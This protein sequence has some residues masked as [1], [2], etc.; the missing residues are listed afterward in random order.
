MDAIKRK[1]L[2]VATVKAAAAGRW[3]D[4][5]QRAGVA[6]DLLDG[7]H[8][9]CPK[10]GGT[11]RFRVVD[12]G[13]GACLC[14]KCFRD[15]NGD[16]LAAVMWLLGLDFKDALEWT[17]EQVG[18]TSP[19][20]GG[21]VAVDPLELLARVKRC[22]VEGLRRYGA[23]TV[24]DAVSFPVFLRDAVPVSSFKIWPCESGRRG[25]G[26]LAKGKPSGVFLPK[27]DT[28]SPRLPSPGESWLVVEGVK[29]AAAASDLGRLAIGLNGCVIP[30]EAAPLLS[31]VDVVLVPD[32]DAAGDHGAEQSA[33][34]LSGLA[35]SVRIA[36]LPVPW[37]ES[38]G[39][40]LRDAVRLAGV[41]SV[42][43]SLDAAEA[44]SP[45]PVK[46]AD[47]V[48]I[49]ESQ[50]DQQ[51]DRL[52]EVLAARG[53]L[54]QRADS[55]VIVKGDGMVPLCVDSL[56]FLASKHT[57]LVLGGNPVPWS[58]PVLRM[59][60]R[61]P[62][63]WPWVPVLRGVV[64][65][66]VVVRDGRVLVDPG[67]DRESG[68]WVVVGASDV[69]RG[70]TVCGQDAARELM[71]ELRSELFQDFPFKG[72][73]AAS[74]L[75]ASILTIMGRFAFDGPS[76][77]MVVNA[78]TPGCGKG[79]LLDLV[80][81]V[82]TGGKAS[83]TPCR[84]D[85]EF[86]KAIVPILAKGTRM[87][88]L[89]NVPTGSTVG[90]PVLD[91][92]ATSETWTD[93]ILGASSMSGELPCTTTWF[94]TGN[95]LS[96]GSDTARRTLMISL[97]SDLESPE[98]RPEDGFRHDNVKGWAVKHRGRLAWMA[99]AVLSE[100]IRAGLPKQNLPAW[101][102][103]EGW[104]RV[105]RSCVVWA[106]LPDPAETRERLV[107]KSRDELRMIMAAWAKADPEGRG[108]TSK[109]AVNCPELADAWA[110]VMVGDV[111]ARRVG[112]KLQKVSGRV[113][114]GRRF[115]STANSQNINTWRLVEVSCPPPD[116]PGNHREPDR[117]PGPEPGV[118]VPG[119]GVLPPGGA[120]LV[121]VSAF[122]GGD[123]G[124]GP[125]G[126]SPPKS[127]GFGEPDREPRE[128][129][130]L[131]FPDL[132]GQNGGQKAAGFGKNDCINPG[133]VQYLGEPPGTPGTSGTC[134]DPWNN[135]TELSA[136]GCAPDAI[137]SPLGRGLEKGSRGSQ[138]P[139][140]GPGGGGDAADRVTAEQYPGDHQNG[141]SAAAL[142]GI[143]LAGDSDPDLIDTVSGFSRVE[144]SAWVESVR[145][146]AAED[147]AGK[148]WRAVADV[149]RRC[150]DGPSV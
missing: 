87:A 147:P 118:K 80:A 129:V 97:E 5:L 17:A 13:A 81:V 145:S 99:A 128:P 36:K 107:D 113:C 83:R 59:A 73:A 125:G 33:K 92:L 86:R 101:G 143:L 124:D 117:E 96:L 84:S 135:S 48:V 27:D 71:A 23:E 43:A 144:L 77:L 12:L 149:R 57:C 109:D 49:T 63:G 82:A 46:G 106:G 123:G 146:R 133:L 139:G 136:A 89:D 40:D 45:S 100:F 62:E 98:A 110:E 39:G 60:L 88:L 21:G 38:G 79:L 61:R 18:L 10:C 6:P 3:S 104:S 94:M 35:R 112:M 72:E 25:K 47:R 66:P 93:R 74:A 37:S 120:V 130:D 114:G 132:D 127:G 102:S 1:R 58:P 70:E 126:C 111:N 15:R 140:A 121:G 131:R 52:L 2:D 24:K 119:G 32:R 14:G 68:L 85:E 69:E 134:L 67:F 103:Y 116:N 150:G 11:D 19:G 44:W 9:P 31:G 55:L 28:G 122:T 108:M 30:V 26:L 78:N 142:C 148:G 91:A 76:P 64:S 42:L 7:R 137:T 51:A 50:P 65:A 53:V 141:G 29:D 41:P 115:V 105:I 138:V 4:L 75:M 22:S 8:H 54:F 20:A 56:A 34:R 95:S 90:G 16:G